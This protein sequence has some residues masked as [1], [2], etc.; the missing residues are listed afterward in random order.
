MKDSTE[1]SEDD[2][3]KP[4]VEV[5]NAFIRV[6]G[7]TNH[8]RST[9]RKFNLKLAV[10]T[11]EEM[12]ERGEAPNS[13]TFKRLLEACENLLPMG[14]E[15]SR[16]VEN[17]FNNCSYLGLVNDEVLAQLKNAASEELFTDMVVAKTA[18]EDI[19]GTLRSGKMVPESWTRNIGVKV[20]TV[21]GKQPKALNIDAIFVVTKRVK[22]F[23]TRNLRQHKNKKLLRSGRD[24]YVKN[25][26]MANSP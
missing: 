10:R 21:D 5:F 17:I 24:L 13:A 8:G 6:C 26:R 16:A 20:E 3:V 22:E 19:E 23:R 2:H 11:V 7:S 4:T 12:R 14:K 15:R 9:E 18:E 25:S 1:G